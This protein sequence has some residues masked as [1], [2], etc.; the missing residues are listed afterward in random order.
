[1]MRKNTQRGFSVFLSVIIVGVLSL[2]VFF[3]TSVGSKETI[4]STYNRESQYAYFA[5]D[6]GIECAL[7][8]DSRSVSAF[9]TSTSGSPINCN[10]V[11][12]A[13]NVTI[14]GT[15]TATTRI[16]GGGDANA[17]STF[18]FSLTSGQNPTSA[19]VI[20]TVNKRYIGP[21]L[22]TSIYSRGYNNCVTTDDRRVERGIEVRY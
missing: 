11:S 21:N 3:I 10:G 4:F 7:F 1:M 6:A 14:A 13:T 12:M 9:S 18:G 20:V 2:I 5:A 22:A 15:T 17:T 19:C 16:G 8:W